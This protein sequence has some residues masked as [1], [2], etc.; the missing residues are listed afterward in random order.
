MTTTDRKRDAHRMA[1]TACPAPFMGGSVGAADLPEIGVT[2]ATQSL[3]PV[4][5]PRELFDFLM[6]DGEI[7]GTSFG[8]LNDRLPE[9]FWWRALMRTA[10]AS[11]SHSIPGDVGIGIDVVKRAEAIINAH[12]EYTDGFDRGQI[13]FGRDAVLRMILAALT[14]SALSGDAGEGE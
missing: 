7:D 3:L 1:E 8:D 9:R 13:Y 4:T 14:P 12:A 2:E 11:Q 10:E 6:G 5:I